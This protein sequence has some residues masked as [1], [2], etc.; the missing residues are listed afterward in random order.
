LKDLVENDDGDSD[1]EV[2]SKWKQFKAFLGKFGIFKAWRSFDNRFVI[3][4]RI[5]F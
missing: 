3:K 1:N 4:R 5:L 2:P